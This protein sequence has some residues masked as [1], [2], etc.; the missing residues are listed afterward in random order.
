MTADSPPLSI[1]AVVPAHNADSYMESCLCGLFAAGFAAPDIVVADDGSR[2]NT[3]EIVRQHGLEPMILERN[4]GAAGARN[5]AAAIA[6]ADIILFVDADVIVRPDVR[7]R[8]LAWFSRPDAPAAVFGSYDDTPTRPETVSRLR[9]LLHH[10]VHHENAGPA[11]TFWTGLGA[12][13]R[14]VFESIGGFDASVAMMEDIELG[15]RLHQA[16]YQIELDPSIQ[17]THQKYWSVRGMI[18]TDLWHRA[19][20]WTRLMSS[21]A[22]RQAP[23][24]LNVSSGAKLSVGLVG[25]CLLCLAA[26][27]VVGAAGPLAACGSIGALAMTNRSFLA[28]VTRLDGPRGAVAALG[29]LWLHY[30]CAG[31]GYALVKLRL[32]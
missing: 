31:A 30:F 18:R 6:D 5:R 14:E 10:H 13:R 2:D 27:P 7:E 1:C 19:V 4:L 32:V 20:P 16:G 8:V 25:F 21:A 9:N 24:S 26:L 17:G 3:V 12:I 15:M 11:S 28:L 23:E 29:V 22:G